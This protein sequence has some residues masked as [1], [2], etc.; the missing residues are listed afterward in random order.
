MGQNHSQSLTGR[1]WALEGHRRVGDSATPSNLGSDAHGSSQEGRG[2]NRIMGGGRERSRGSERSAPCPRMET[3]KGRVHSGRR[4]AGPHSAP[5][6]SGL[7]SGTAGLIDNVVP[8]SHVTQSLGSLISFISCL[9]LQ[10]T[11]AQLTYLPWGL[12]RWW[13]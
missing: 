10:M 9:V 2:T 11:A 3:G 7:G 5:W 4:R 6:T 12:K 13:N 8:M 1:G